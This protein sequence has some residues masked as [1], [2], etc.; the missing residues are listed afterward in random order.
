MPALC[1]TY[2]IHS[3]NLRAC[4]RIVPLTKPSVVIAYRHLSKSSSKIAPA[5]ALNTAP[6]EFTPNTSAAS[7]HERSTVIKDAARSALRCNDTTPTPALPFDV[8][9]V[10]KANRAAG[11]KLPA[12]S[13]V[14]S[15]YALMGPYIQLAKPRLTVL[16]MLSA[17]CSYALSPYPATVLELL[18]LT[19]GTTL[20]SAAAN[21]IN[22]GREPD[23][24]RQ[25]MRTQA[26][27][28][29]RGLVTPMQAYKFSAVSGVIG[30]AIL[31]AGV[32]PTVALL[33]ASNIVLYS[34]FYT[35][36]KRKHIINTWFGAIT[37]AIPPLMGWAAASPL[38]HPGCWCLA[39]LLY[40]WQFPHFNTL[41]H[42]I[43]NE[44]KNAG[45][46]MTAWKNPKLNARVAL[47][48]SL[49][50]FPLCFGLS[51]Y[52][53]TDW[54]YQIDSA[55]V[56]GWMSFWAFKFWWQQRYNYSKKVYNNK[57]E[58]NKGMVLANVYARKTF[59]VSVLHLPAVLILAIV[60]KKGR[61]DW[62]FSDEGKLV[63]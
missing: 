14:L 41:S 1:A 38:T 46:V 58:F 29:V 17:I 47:R 50:M 27:P 22:M 43:R 2:L 62:L 34:W 52:G 28:V 16:V 60:H 9:R 53:I 40:A 3:G 56:N 25:M 10:D 61:W 48:Y 35:S 26:R 54:T 23:F 5:A 20:C 57:A 36:L 15:A 51:Y 49:L 31:Y 11:R 59:W 33:G 39:G 19:V 12:A 6:I 24:D 42:N 13:G 32:N 63:A 18:S 55:L 30:T 7:L 4:L 8:K 44:Y 21:G 37:G 45:H